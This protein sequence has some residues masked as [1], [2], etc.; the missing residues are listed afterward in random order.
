MFV[1]CATFILCWI[2]TIYFY[3]GTS[4]FA[5]DNSI[6]WIGAVSSIFLPFIV[7]NI[8][9]WIC[10]KIKAKHNYSRLMRDINP[11]DRIKTLNYYYRWKVSTY[12]LNATQHKIH[13]ID[14]KGKRIINIDHVID[15]EIIKDSEVIQSSSS[16]GAVVGAV[17]AGIPGALIGHAL[18]N[19]KKSTKVTGY[20]IRFIFDNPLVPIRNM[21]FL[22]KSI[23]GSDNGVRALVDRIFAFTISCMN[24]KRK[25]Y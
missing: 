13:F 18:S 5:A 1:G 3:A 12:I 4:N 7:S 15:C 19:P 14:H 21:V 25:R 22:G 6:L 23:S 10:R 20:Y 24:Q 17:I 8:F 11:N 2:I 16:D 9:R